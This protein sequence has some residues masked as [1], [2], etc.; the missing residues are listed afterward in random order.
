MRDSRLTE[1]GAQHTFFLHRGITGDLHMKTLFA[2]VVVGMLTS[3]AL[4]QVNMQYDG[5]ANGQYSGQ[6]DTRVD[7]R[8][9]RNEGLPPSAADKATGLY[10]SPINPSDCAEL[11]ALNP[12]ARVRAQRRIERECNEE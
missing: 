5:Q 6:V 4:A 11:Q 1:G 10:E 2:A 3:S 7:G 8:P 12:D 9:N